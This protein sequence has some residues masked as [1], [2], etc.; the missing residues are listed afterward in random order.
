MSADPRASATSPNEND[1]S[2]ATPAPSRSQMLSSE[3]SV[4][5]ISTAPPP[6]PRPDVAALRAAALKSKAK[7]DVTPSPAPTLPPKPAKKSAKAAK[8][9]PAKAGK[10]ANKASKL[11]S[12]VTLSTSEKEDGEISDDNAPGP[13]A[14]RREAITRS[15]PPPSM[16]KAKTLQAQPSVDHIVTPGVAA[17]DSGIVRSTVLTISNT[18][19]GATATS[20][21]PG[22]PSANGLAEQEW[23]KEIRG[24]L[25]DGLTP[26]DLVA[27]GAPTHLVAKVC[28]DIVAGTK[29]RRALWN[30]VREPGREASE[31]PSVASFGNEAGP[32]RPS[33]IRSRSSSPDIAVAVAMGRTSSESSTEALIERMIP[34]QPYVQ[35]SAPRIMSSWTPNAAVP[36]P[37]SNLSRPT[38]ATGAIHI[39]SYRPLPRPQVPTP[40]L[41]PAPQHLPHKGRRRRDLDHAHQADALATLNYGDDDESSIP[42]PP[43]VAPPPIP[44]PPPVPAEPAHAAV[45]ERL[46]PSP[47]DLIETRRR[48]LL[49]MRRGKTATPTTPVSAAP[50]PPPQAGPSTAVMAEAASLEREILGSTAEVPMDID[51]EMEDGEIPDD[52]PEPTP[53]PRVASAT[54]SSTRRG[55]KRPHAEDMMDNTSRPTTTAYRPAPPKRR[56]FCVPPPASRLL[57]LLD[58][59]S[60]SDDEHEDEG[61]RTISIPVI[62]IPEPVDEARLLA[63]RKEAEL[64]E[65]NANILRLKEQIAAKLAA[66]KASVTTPTGAST[67]TIERRVADAEEAAQRVGVDGVAADVVHAAVLAVAQE[68]KSKGGTH[69]DDDVPMEVADAPDATAST[70]DAAT[71]STPSSSSVPRSST[72]DPSLALCRSEAGGGHCADSSYA[73]MTTYMKQSLTMKRGDRET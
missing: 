72:N 52:R 69:P 44:P 41:A 31:S 26:K 15:K 16:P 67:P 61:L 54:S 55:V 42:A 39:E 60:D 10:S 43:S 62:V 28:E 29:Q 8:A 3:P 57:I 5:R 30:Q 34:P 1:T 38:S 47:A 22:S 32:S 40:V 59:D 45:P 4:P 65:K 20:S 19:T 27:Q 71:T 68:S 50:T 51:D 13:S 12:E 21:F 9:A 35:P 58:D 2:S 63:E 18:F 7:N 73:D 56:L 6:P 48:A 25:H 46:G 33:S 24:F 36:G 49:S 64:R 70:S 66:K 14:P 11:S 53:P 23:L 17:S 37:A